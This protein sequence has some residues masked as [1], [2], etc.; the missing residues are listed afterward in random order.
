MQELNELL[1]MRVE[2]LDKELQATRVKLLTKD[3]ELTKTI[4]T[5]NNLKDERSIYQW[6]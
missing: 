3:R 2:A 1:R 6:N 5:L 4:N